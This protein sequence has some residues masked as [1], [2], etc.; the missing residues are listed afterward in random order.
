[1]K[2]QSLAAELFHADGQTETDMTKPMVAFHNF[3]T[4][5]KNGEM[6]IMRNFM[7]PYLHPLALE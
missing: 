6:F 5:S 3:V 7:T 4:T 1:M 2:I